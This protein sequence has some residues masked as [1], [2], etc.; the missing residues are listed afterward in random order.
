M[1]RRWSDI[2]IELKYKIE[3]IGLP[4]SRVLNFEGEE[5]A[6]ILLDQASLQL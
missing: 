3:A 1:T 4:A 2:W 5:F 6:I